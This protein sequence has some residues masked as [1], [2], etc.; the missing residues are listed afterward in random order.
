MLENTVTV[1]IILPLFSK[2][3]SEI[4]MPQKITRPDWQEYFMDI[5]RLVARRSTCMRRQVGAILVKDKRVL[6]TGYNGSPAGLAHCEDVGCI[7]AQNSVPSG[8]RHELCRGLHAEQNT[9]I[10]AAFHGVSIKGATLFCTNL[11]CSI[12]LKMLINAGIKQ[13]IFDE[14]YPDKLAE[15][16]LKEADLSL[17]KFK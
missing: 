1:L 8:Q 2:D 4:Y 13:I 11:P 6:A 14:G 15:S 17:T 7:R 10:Q 5:T 3:S 9:I 12:C 16:L